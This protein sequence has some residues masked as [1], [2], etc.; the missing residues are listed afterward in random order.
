MA[1]YCHLLSGQYILCGLLRV[2]AWDFLT[3]GHAV[4][5]VGGSNPDRGTTVGGVFHPTRSLARLSPPNMPYIVNSKFIY[6]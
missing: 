3:R 5:E 4:W 6:N 1:Q 2:R